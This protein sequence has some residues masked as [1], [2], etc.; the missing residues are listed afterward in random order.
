MQAQADQDLNDLF[1]KEKIHHFSVNIEVEFK[2]K[3]KSNLP[4]DNLTVQI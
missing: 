2:N 4:N 3:L 1:R